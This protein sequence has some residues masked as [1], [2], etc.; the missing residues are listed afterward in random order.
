M[1]RPNRSSSVR[2][3]RSSRRCRVA[4]SLRPDPLSPAIFTRSSSAAASAA[5]R[6]SRG[7]APAVASSSTNSAAMTAT[8]APVPS[9]RLG[10]DRQAA[11]RTAKPSS[12][13]SSRARSSRP[14]AASATSAATSGA[15]PSSTSVAASRS[16]PS[17]P[18]SMR[19]QRDA[20]VTSSGGTWSARMTKIVLAGGSSTTLSRGATASWARWNSVSSSTLRPASFGVRMASRRISRARLDGQEGALPLDHHQVGVDLGQGPGAHVAPVGP[21]SGAQ[22]GG[23]QRPGRRPL[24]GARRPDQQVGVDR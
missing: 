6:A 3:R 1:A 19:T 24:A 7:A 23:G 21:A 10:T 11:R 18:K 2:S 14:P 17:G 22:Q 8:V 15:T 4:R 13:A 20:M 12:D 9:R 16:V 5:W